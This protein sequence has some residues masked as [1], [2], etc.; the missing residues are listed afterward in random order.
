MRISEASFNGAVAIEG[1][2]PG[3]WRVGGEVI[4]GPVLVGAE[5]ARGWGGYGDAATLL[6]LAGQVDV[7][8]IGTG[9][10]MAYLPKAL[11]EALEAAGL[12]IEP[13][14]SAAAARTYNVLVSEGRRVAAA[15]LP[16]A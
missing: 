10:E 16:A 11:R 12:G 14:G 4:A 6:S 9:P 1:Y 13:M 5:G 3:F 7:L 15:L 8:L 2:G